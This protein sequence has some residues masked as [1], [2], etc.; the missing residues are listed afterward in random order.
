VGIL[1][2]RFAL[3]LLIVVFMDSNPLQVGLGKWALKV[4]LQVKKGE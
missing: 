4:P 2:A 1:E 3:L